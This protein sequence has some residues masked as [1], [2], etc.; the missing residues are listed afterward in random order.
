MDLQKFFIKSYKQKTLAQ[1][2]VFLCLY[3]TKILPVLFAQITRVLFQSR[4]SE[5]RFVC[6]QDT[7]LLAK[8]LHSLYTHTSILFYFYFYSTS[9]RNEYS[10]RAR[11]G[12]V[13]DSSKAEFCVSSEATKKRNPSQIPF[14]PIIPLTIIIS[15]L[16]KTLK[17]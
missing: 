10:S 7:P 4:F 15:H 14:L 8:R 17:S 3:R 5:K 6:V 11:R 13:E 2:K 9:I 12:F 1:T 16:V